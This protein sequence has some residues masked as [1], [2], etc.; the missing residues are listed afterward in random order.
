MPVIDE[1]DDLQYMHQIDDDKL[2]TVN[3]I[4]I[5]TGLS[6]E[7]IY[8]NGIRPGTL[9]SRLIKG[10]HRRVVTGSDLKEWVGYNG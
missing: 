10:Q 1:R 5:I 9:I 2:Y 3:Q 4:M 8:T 7:T 6:K